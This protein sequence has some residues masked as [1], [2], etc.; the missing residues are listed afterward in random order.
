[1][2]FGQFI[3]TFFLRSSLAGRGCVA[4]LGTAGLASASA[5]D[6]VTDVKPILAHHCVSCHGPIKQNAG[7]RLDAGS[8]ILKGAKKGAVLLAH[9]ADA[10]EMIKRVISKDMDDRMPPEGAALNEKEIQI[11]TAWITEGAP[12]PADEEIVDPK[13]HWFFKVPVKAELP[14]SAGY[15]TLTHPVNRFIAAEWVARA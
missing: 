9:A 7:L 12:V 1:M 2:S 4:L 6:F 13:N 8:L 15:E 3:A 14:T 5:V 11:L 10:S